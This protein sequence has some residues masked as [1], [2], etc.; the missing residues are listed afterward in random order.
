MST[1]ALIEYVRGEWVPVNVDVLATP[2]ECSRKH[3]INMKLSKVET[4]PLKVQ[5]KVNTQ[6]P[7]HIGQRHEVTC[8]KTKSRPT[9]A[10]PS[11]SRGQT[12]NTQHNS[13]AHS[14]NGR[15]RSRTPSPNRGF[16]PFNNNYN[17]MDDITPVPDSISEFIADSP[18]LMTFLPASRPESP[19]SFINNPP[20]V[21]EFN[22]YSVPAGLPQLGLHQLHQRNNTQQYQQQ[23]FLFGHSRSASPTPRTDRSSEFVQAVL[24]KNVSPRIDT[25][26]TPRYSLWTN[27]RMAASAEDADARHARFPHTGEGPYRQ[28]LMHKD[29]EIRDTRSPPTHLLLKHEQKHKEKQVETERQQ[30]AWRERQEAEWKFHQK[31]KKQLKASHVQQ[32]AQLTQSREQ[33][34]RKAQEHNE[35]YIQEL[36]AVAG[37]FATAGDVSEIPAADHTNS[38]S[39]VPPLV[40]RASLSSAQLMNPDPPGNQEVALRMLSRQPSVQD[41]LGP[42]PSSSS[43]SHQTL[44]RGPSSRTMS[45]ELSRLKSSTTL[46]SE[47]DP[48]SP[49]SPPPPHRI[50]IHTNSVLEQNIVVTSESDQGF[51]RP[52]FTT[53]HYKPALPP[54]QKSERVLEHPRDTNRRQIQRDYLGVLER[55]MSQ[56]QKLLE[57]DMGPGKFL[58]YKQLSLVDQQRKQIQAEKEFQ[59]NRSKFHSFRCSLPYEESLDLEANRVVYSRQPSMASMSSP[60]KSSKMSGKVSTKMSVRSTDSSGKQ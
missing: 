50:L 55:K 56:N 34:T 47:N 7:A 44:Y 11:R 23:H 15:S 18:Y 8:H 1:R 13:R 40:R 17:S 4:S 19:V 59:S 16:S 9:T 60:K 2:N 12:P 20:A 25:H 48:P 33:R 49:I 26:A 28:L 3:K 39:V 29:K 35:N 52:Y 37:T 58:E 36:H 22:S 46:T 45:A 57:D 5:M 31:M 14:R 53:G 32:H 24:D 38:D 21:D 54:K 51:V 41:S 30:R 43:P 42:L 10:S 27:S 6:S